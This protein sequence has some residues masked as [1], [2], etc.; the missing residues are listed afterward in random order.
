MEKKQMSLPIEI[1]IPLGILMILGFTT[2]CFKA[3][4]DNYGKG[5]E[6]K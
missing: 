6:S 1:Q 2:L 4:K 5:A 3:W